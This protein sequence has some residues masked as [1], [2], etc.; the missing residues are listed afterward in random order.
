MTA[1]GISNGSALR[2]REEGGGRED[3]IPPSPGMHFPS[4]NALVKKN[5]QEKMVWKSLYDNLGG[6]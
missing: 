2:G 1:G 5:V 3:G 4:L 6:N